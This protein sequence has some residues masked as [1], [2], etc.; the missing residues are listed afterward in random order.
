VNA[1][2]KM[3]LRGEKGLVNLANDLG[4]SENNSDGTVLA[5]GVT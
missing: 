2:M 5:R 1:S 4:V 3:N